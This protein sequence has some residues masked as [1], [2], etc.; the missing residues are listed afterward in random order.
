MNGRMVWITRVWKSVII[1]YV[2]LTWLV[3]YKDALVQKDILESVVV[4]G[5][6]HLD[7][8][9]AD[10]GNKTYFFPSKRVLT[11]IRYQSYQGDAFED[12]I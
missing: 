5:E 2:N 11:E 6:F 3:T 7:V 1:D 4:A 10:S 12:K 8:T 9:M